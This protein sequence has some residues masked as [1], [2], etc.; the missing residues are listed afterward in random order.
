LF[1]NLEKEKFYSLSRKI[2][3]LL[4]SSLLLFCSES[5]NE[6]KINNPYL[7]PNPRD[8]SALSILFIGNSL[9]GYNNM[10]QT[11]KIF[12]DSTNKNIF[13]DE[14]VVYGS[15]LSDHLTNPSTMAKINDRQW[16][17]IIIQGRNYTIAHVDYR[18]DDIE[19]IRGIYNLVKGNSSNTNVIFVL[20]YSLKRNNTYDGR[21][22]F[23]HS[24]FQD[25]MYSGTKTIC[26]NIGMQIAPVGW[27]WK[28][29][30]ADRND[31]DLY[32]T[33]ESHPSK[34]GSFLM[35][36]VN[37]STIFREVSSGIN[38]FSNLSPETAL[39]LQRISSAT[40]LD[41]LEMWNLD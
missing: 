19:T 28:E 17:H 12:A 10:T 3:S 39:Y 40:V 29:V 20:A 11:F 34:Y 1:N 8:S 41:N 18:T 33:D 31:F 7:D 9:T 4:F 30:F 27:V 25:L 32:D 37:F 16:D 36:C 21:T 38:Y 6:D 13:V 23:N 15:S 2:L 35:A 24:D 5:N 14:A 26:E 22:Y